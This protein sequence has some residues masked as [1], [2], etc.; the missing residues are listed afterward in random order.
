LGLYSIFARKNYGELDPRFFWR[1]I[2]LSK[3]IKC[4][5]KSSQLQCF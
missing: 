2:H 5:L 1:S 4:G 3:A